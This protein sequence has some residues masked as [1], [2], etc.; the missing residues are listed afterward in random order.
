MLKSFIIIHP[1]HFEQLLFYHCYNKARTKT[2]TDLLQSNPPQH[3]PAC[4][5]C[6]V[7]CPQGFPGITFNKENNGDIYQLGSVY[8]GYSMPS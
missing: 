6:S 2:S 4:N 8:V 1:I 5:H 3:L 7:F